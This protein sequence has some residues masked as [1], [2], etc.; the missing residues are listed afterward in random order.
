MV[1]HAI[2]CLLDSI[3]MS[4]GL[5]HELEYEWRSSCS[6]FWGNESWHTNPDR[7]STATDFFR[8]IQ[9]SSYWTRLSSPPLWGSVLI[10]FITY[11]PRIWFVD[12][13][14]IFLERSSPHLRTEGIRS[15]TLYSYILSWIPSK[16]S[17]TT[18]AK[19]TVIEREVDGDPVYDLFTRFCGGAYDRP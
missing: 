17:P 15:L 14:V 7:W 3:Y 11:Q 4:M 2:A 18:F 13:L 8:K 16:K 12:S 9:L 1:F 6:S 19:C 5:C 10:S